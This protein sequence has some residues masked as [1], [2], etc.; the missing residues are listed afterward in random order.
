MTYGMLF[1]RAMKSGIKYTPFR[2]DKKRRK[3]AGA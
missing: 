1:T 3:H 2:K